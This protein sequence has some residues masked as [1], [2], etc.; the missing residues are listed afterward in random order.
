MCIDPAGSVVLEAKQDENIFIV[1]T[2]YDHLTKIR[3]KLPFS[4]DWDNFKI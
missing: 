4:S 2:Y 3:E 1:N